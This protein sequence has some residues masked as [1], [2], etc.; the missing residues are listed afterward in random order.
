VKRASSPGALRAARRSTLLVLTLSACATDVATRPVDPTGQG[1]G[2]IPAGAPS[3]ATALSGSLLYTNPSS[4]AQRQADAWRV[5]RPADAAQMDKI[6]SQPVAMWLGEWSGDVRATVSGAVSRAAGRMSVFVAYNIPG[7]DCGGYSAGGIG[8]TA[9]R[10]WVRNIAAGLAGAPA[11]VVVE[12]DALPGMDCLGTAAQEERLALIRDAVDVLKAAGAA[13][14]VDA[15]HARWQPADVMASRLAR[16]AIDRADGFALNVSNFVATDINTAYGAAISQRTGGKHFII[17]VSRNGLGAT[18]DGQWCNPPGRALGVDPTT[19]TGHA[20]V[21]AYLWIKVPGESDGT[22]NGGPSAGGWWPEYALGLAQRRPATVIPPPPPPPPPPP[23]TTPEPEP[24]PEPT[25]EPE[26]APD[27]APVPPPPAPAPNQPP[28]ASTG[29]PYAG[30]QGAPIAMT[31]AGSTDPEGGVLTYRWDFGDGTSAAGATVV[32][33]YADRRTYTVTLTVTDP[34]GATGSASTTVVV[35][36]APPT[37]TF[38]YPGGIRADASYTLA[39]TNATDSSPKDRAAGFTY[40][41][42]CGQG[43]FGAWT[44]SSATTCPATSTT[45]ARTLRARV[46]EMWGYV[47][48]EYR[49]TV[50][51]SR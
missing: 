2:V 35:A 3:A 15:G 9:Y 40:A 19:N 32:K 1:I 12:P 26:P 30:E 18:A 25:P 37:A 41:F 23:D 11:V 42:D 44:S 10:A 20:L 13:V 36:D 7:R 22:C 45:G 31:A 16:A 8:A 50:T 38:V 17:D 4:S 5:T 6:A 48:R 43:W 34:A 46:R 49:V 33:T 47:H 28:V 24:T 29:G 39:L 27:P 14:Y 51:V 21:D